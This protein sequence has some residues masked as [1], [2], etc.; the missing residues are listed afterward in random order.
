MA[1]FALRRRYGLPPQPVLLLRRGVLRIVIVRQHGR[2]EYG[3]SRTPSPTL[4]ND[5]LYGSR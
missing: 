2:T 4:V 5:I 3:T 1:V